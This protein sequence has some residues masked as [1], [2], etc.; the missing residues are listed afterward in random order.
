MITSEKIRTL[1]EKTGAGMMDCKNALLE[2]KGDLESAV[3]WLRKKGV[4]TAAKKSVREAT[5]GLITISENDTQMSILEVNSETDFVA[6]NNNFQQFCLN[7]S[8]TILSNQFGSVND[9][10]DSIFYQSDKKVSEELTNLIS[11]LGENIRIKRF[12]ILSKSSNEFLSSYIHNAVNP[13]SGK[14]GVILKAKSS[15]NVPDLDVFLKN[16]SMHIA[17]TEPKS[18]SPDD[19]KEEIVNREKSIYIE[20][21][22]KSDKPKDIQEKILNGKVKKFYQEVCLLNQSFVM[23]NQ[24]SIQQYIN[25]QMKKYGCV[26][27]IQSFL[28][29]RVGDTVQ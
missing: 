28:F 25:D 12:D 20:Q 8:K 29:Y 2:V 4:N 1:R 23:D 11:K 18:I 26:I 3:D 19:L 7:L 27:N 22:E 15:E 10:L 21:L 24:L 5:D 17:A 16:I 13:N 6:R 14:I 9:I